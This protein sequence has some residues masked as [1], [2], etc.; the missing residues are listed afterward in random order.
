MLNNIT[1]DNFFPVIFKHN[2]VPVQ[3]KSEVAFILGNRTNVKF[4]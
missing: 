2:A 1:E 3:Q 4:L